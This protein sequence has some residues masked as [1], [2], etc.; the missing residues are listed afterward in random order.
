MAD[1]SDSSFLSSSDAS[2]DSFDAILFSGSDNSKVEIVDVDDS[3]SECFIVYADVLMSSVN[4]VRKDTCFV[5]GN[6][7]LDCEKDILRVL[8][9]GSGLL[10]NIDVML[11]E[12]L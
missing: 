5:A 8:L 3:I 9:L 7:A 6:I 4:G 11:Y 2:L 1:L 12:T 10:L